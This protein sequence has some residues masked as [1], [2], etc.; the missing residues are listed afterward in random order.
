MRDGTDLPDNYRV[1]AWR[2]GNDPLELR[3]ETRPLPRPGPGEVLVRNHVIGL[4]PVDWKVLGSPGIEPGNVAGVDGAG[5]VVA[6]GQGVPVAWIGERVA[7]HS[8]IPAHGSYAEY[9][10]LPARVLLRV[11]PQVD[12]VTAAAMPC[13]GLTAQLALNKLPA[14]A[15]GRLFVSGA[16]GS[17]GHF[18]VQMAAAAGW[19]VTARSNTRHHEKLSGFGATNIPN[20]ASPDV[21]HFH[22]VIDMTS[23][24]QAAGLAQALKANGHLVTIQG[25]VDGWIN[26]PFSECRS[27]HEVALGAM[28]AHGDDEDWQSLVRQGEAILSDLATGTLQPEKTVSRPFD[29][30]PEHLD[31][32]KNRNFSGKP[33]VTLSRT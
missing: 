31:A 3:S 30:L 10:P 32:L 14:L 26:D 20:D 12:F 9:T 2:E 27:L 7:Y 13:P 8:N 6:V 18:L 19:S 4:N 17:V 21:G 33:V 22:A 28:H 25:R 1:W 11:P 29:K 24:D 15:K 23:A 5:M 16:G